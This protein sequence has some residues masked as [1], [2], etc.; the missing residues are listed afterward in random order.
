MSQ[1]AGP[2]GATPP[3]IQSNNNISDIP[4]NPFGNIVPPVQNDETPPNGFI[5]PIEQPETPNTGIVQTQN[6]GFNMNTVMTQPITGSEDASSGIANA[7]NVFNNT[8]EQPQILPFNN[9]IPQSNNQSQNMQQPGFT[10]IP[11]F[12][13]NQPM[14]Y[15]NSNNNG[16]NQQP[17]YNIT[18]LFWLINPKF[19]N[20][21]LGNESQMVIVSY[22]ADFNNLT[23]RFTAI[24]QF[25]SQSALCVKDLARLGTVNLYSEHCMELM[26]LQPNQSMN[27]I[28]R[29]FNITNWHP[30]NTIITKLDESSVMVK[31]IDANNNQYIF[32]FTGWQYVA[33]YKSLE[34][35]I[36]GNS[37]NQNVF[38]RNNR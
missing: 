6:S 1:N 34:F 35:M 9:P 29:V 16:N 27:I 4:N 23:L 33:F 32:T 38:S 31:S 26:Y 20:N 14:S 37:W 19:M 22:N 13:Q 25:A 30:N 18:D 2:F 28:E 7:L 15:N 3:D 10:Q 17:K 5:Q 36:N 11:Q 24:N 8:T 21:N 12:N